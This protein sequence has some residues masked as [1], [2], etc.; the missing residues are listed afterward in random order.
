M[1]KIDRIEQNVELRE[2]K[3]YLNVREK[4]YTLT[5]YEGN[6]AILKTN[7]GR[8][9]N[10]YGMNTGAIPEDAEYINNLIVERLELKV[11]DNKTI[12]YC[13]DIAVEWKL[14]EHK[15]II[16]TFLKALDLHNYRSGK[17]DFE[18]AKD[19]SIA[20]SNWKGIKGY[21]RSRAM[22][23]Y[24]KYEEQGLNEL[25]GDL[26]RIELILNAK[27]LEQNNI[28]KISDVQKAREELLEFLGTMKDQ[29]KKINRYSKPTFELI[30]RAF[31]EVTG[32][33]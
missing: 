6:K 1:I 14:I 33:I 18:V 30:S 25:S 3:E 11:M 24:S 26:I 15:H 20:K 22:K 10:E 31:E 27:A 8:T 16:N 28:T 9:L 32:P 23:L 17:L 12:E 21:K 29:I 4:D 19:K 5:L 13:I 2:G 7:P